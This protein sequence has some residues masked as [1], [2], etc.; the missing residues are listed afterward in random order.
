MKLFFP[1]RPQPS[2]RLKTCNYVGKGGCRG[3][4]FLTAVKPWLWNGSV[5]IVVVVVDVFFGV[6]HV[7]TNT[8]SKE[9]PNM[10]RSYLSL[11]SLV[12]FPAAP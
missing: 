6:A 2:T 11:L 8:G 1:L 7:Y 5:V 12:P 10:T 3:G 4:P 9:K